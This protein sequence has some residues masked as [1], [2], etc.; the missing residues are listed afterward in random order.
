MYKKENKNGKVSPGDVRD[1]LMVN[2]TRTKKY[3]EPFDKTWKSF[4]FVTESKILEIT[5]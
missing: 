2:G 3:T 4:F 5:I 1:S